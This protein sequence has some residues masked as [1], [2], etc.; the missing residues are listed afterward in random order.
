[1]LSQPKVSK[2]RDFQGSVYLKKRVKIDKYFGLR[3][4][5]LEKEQK[6]VRG[7]KL[8]NNHLDEALQNV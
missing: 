1:M 8:I 5:Q 3:P 4:V 7:K 6:Q 2:T